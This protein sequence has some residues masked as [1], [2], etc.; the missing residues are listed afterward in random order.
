MVDTQVSPTAV[1]YETFTPGLEV[2]LVFVAVRTTEDLISL[3]ALV[4]L[5]RARSPPLKTAMLAM[6]GLHCARL[7]MLSQVNLLCGW[8]P[9]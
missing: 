1:N 3:S 2:V 8:L 7:R 4:R 5:L 6:L 9:L